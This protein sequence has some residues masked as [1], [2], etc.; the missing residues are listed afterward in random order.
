MTTNK[1][2]NMLNM[3][4]TTEFFKNSNNKKLRNIVD[5]EKITDYYEKQAL[6]NIL[7]TNIIGL[8]NP[9][10][11]Q[12]KDGKYSISEKSAREQWNCN[13]TMTESMRG[14]DGMKAGEKSL[15]L[16]EMA[17]NK[18]F[19]PT[20]L[21]NMLNNVIEIISKQV[22]SRK[23]C[24]KLCS[25]FTKSFEYM[26]SINKPQNDDE[27]KFPYVILD[28]HS[29]LAALFLSYIKEEG[30]ESFKPGSLI[31]FGIENEEDFNK[32]TAFDGKSR[33]KYNHDLF[34]KQ[35]AG[36][37]E[38]LQYSIVTEEKV[39]QLS[40][41]YFKGYGTLS[42]LS[43]IFNGNSS[44]KTSWPIGQ[45]CRYLTNYSRVVEAALIIY[46]AENSKKPIMKKGKYD[47]KYWEDLS[48]EM[49]LFLLGNS[50]AVNE[51][52]NDIRYCRA[53]S[54]DLLNENMKTIKNR[55][56]KALY[57][58]DTY[59]KVLLM[60]KNEQN[61]K[62]IDAYVARISKYSE[63][64]FL[65]PKAFVKDYNVLQLYKDGYGEQPRY[66]VQKFLSTI[67]AEDVG[68]EFSPKNFN[69]WLEAYKN[70]VLDKLLEK[71]KEKTSLIR[72]LLE[73][74]DVPEKYW[75]AVENMYLEASMPI[76]K[77]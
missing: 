12:Y 14:L 51:L 67:N 32:A 1:K 29:R 45:I 68:E 31:P 16:S 23:T 58:L 21:R 18:E 38:A 19:C 4:A 36:N 66:F 72:S 30:Y 17:V 24:D 15:V 54:F 27:E 10:N 26:T 5:C 35:K 37:S 25:D 7:P 28:G 8:N 57:E 61:P 52:L 20:E 74:S 11:L 22:K 70:T 2:S 65:N 46:A 48:L 76:N 50:Q 39:K 69:R 47:W 49:M 41:K 56:S 59:Q 63:N 40:Q 60:S 9:R 43:L 75:N 53:M 71:R 64:G 34:V 13:K 73:T 6:S 3:E 77:K 42:V 62:Y 33:D 55:P 44:G